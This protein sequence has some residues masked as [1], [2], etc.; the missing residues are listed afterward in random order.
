MDLKKPFILLVLFIALF[1]A[2]IALSGRLAFKNIAQPEG[3]EQ[4]LVDERGVRIPPQR[5]APKESDL[6]V[7]Q[8]PKGFQLLVSYVDSGFEPQSAAIKAGDTV[9]F[10][11]NSRRAVW[12]AADGRG[13]AIYPG[14]ENGCG[15][16]ALD[17]CRALQPGEYWE[18]AFTEKGTWS[19]VNNLDKNKGG[20]LSVTVR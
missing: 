18:F 15:S 3:S 16:S 5:P 13:G 9:R 19:F 11:N 8:N 1:I 12:I 7:N 10:T 2:L 4:P 6:I 20:S 17:S 14:M